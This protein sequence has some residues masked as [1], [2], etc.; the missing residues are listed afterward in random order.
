MILTDL[1]A[2]AYNAWRTGAGR[3]A[4][5]SLVSTGKAA[6]CALKCAVPAQSF[7]V[8]QSRRKTRAAAAALANGEW[9]MAKTAG[10]ALGK[11]VAGR[12]QW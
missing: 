4:R 7:G 2:R 1:D 5:M 9:R 8:G 6:R 12:L 11:H 10:K 3:F